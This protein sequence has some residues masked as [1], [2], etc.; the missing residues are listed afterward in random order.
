MLPEPSALRT[1]LMNGLMVQRD[2][3][4]FGRLEIRVRFP[5]GPL[6]EGSRIR[7][8]GPLC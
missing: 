2:D 5:V 1:P 3:T 6:M 7:L 8:A 4:S